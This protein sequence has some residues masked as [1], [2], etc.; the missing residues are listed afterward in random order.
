MSKFMLAAVSALALGAAPA[1]AQLLGN[2]GGTVSG[3]LNGTLGGTLN[4]S[5]SLGTLGNV[6]GAVNGILSGPASIANSV[7]AVGSRS[8]KGSASGSVDRRN[9][10]AGGNVGLAGT[11]TGAV[12]GATSAA[13]AGSVLNGSGSAS[14]GASANKNVGFGVQG[15]GTDQA[16]ALAGQVAGTANVVA[17]T[18][19]G[20]DTHEADPIS[21]FKL[22]TSDYAPMARRIASLGLPTL[23]VMEGGYAVDALGANVAAFLSGF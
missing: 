16:H 9:G 7:S 18:A 8:A 22:K 17:S 10:S 11:V 12:N 13:L 21:H 2:V 14:G 3:A 1:E 5:G 15:V 23:I 20:A 6:G 4:S 19:Y